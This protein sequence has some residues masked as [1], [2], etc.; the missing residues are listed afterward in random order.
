MSLSE[1]LFIII[2]GVVLIVL[3]SDALYAMSPVSMFYNECHWSYN[4]WACHFSWVKFTKAMCNAGLAYIG[5]VLIGSND[6]LR[7][8]RGEHIGN[9][10]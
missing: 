4:D 2:P 10:S 8:P 6:M 7:N 1:K 5:V 9:D 3:V